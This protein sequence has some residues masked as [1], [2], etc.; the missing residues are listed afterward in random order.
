MIPDFKTYI[1]ESVWADM[2]RRSNGNLE[3][4]EDDISSLNRDGLF[5]HI[6]NV[7]EMINDFPRPLTSQTS[8]AHTYFSIPIFKSNSN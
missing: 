3:R 8:Q 5:E 7:Y 2:H 6:F 4:K 1:G